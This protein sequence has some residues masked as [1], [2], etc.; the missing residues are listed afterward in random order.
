MNRAAPRPSDSTR[1]Y[2]STVVAINRFAT[3]FCFSFCFCLGGSQPALFAAVVVMYVLGSSTIAA[4]IGRKTSQSTALAIYS[5]YGPN[6]P[7]VRDKESCCCCCVHRSPPLS[8][9][10]P[11]HGTCYHTIYLLLS[12]STINICGGG[13]GCCFAESRAGVWLGSL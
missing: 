11:R 4:C 3:A 6:G 5:L 7:Q 9:P 1:F 12:L 2:E 10:P 8:P 13:G